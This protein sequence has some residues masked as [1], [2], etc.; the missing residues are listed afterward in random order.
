M[1]GIGTINF[2]GLA[3]GLDTQQ[4]IEDLMKIDSKP[5]DRLET[6][7]TTLK[8]QSTVFNAM[9]TSLTDLKNAIIDLKSS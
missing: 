1:A 4:L 8:E 9:K 3:S 5:L 2:G 7:Q 6:R